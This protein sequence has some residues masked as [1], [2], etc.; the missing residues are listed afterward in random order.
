[1]A[2]YISFDWSADT[3][4]LHLMREVA[5][6]V[7]FWRRER[8]GKIN[9]N[10][11]RSLYIVICVTVGDDA[12]IVPFINIVGFSSFES[13]N[14]AA[15]L[16]LMR[17]VAEVENFRRR[18]RMEKHLLNYF[19]QYYACNSGGLPLIVPYTVYS[20]FTDLPKNFRLFSLPWLTPSPCLSRH[21]VIMA[22]KRQNRPFIR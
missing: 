3:A 22:E 19:A 4:S 6:V 9:G 1:M 13:E 14:I 7:D 17:E 2:E 10:A 11:F 5:K 15:S 8:T 12:Y 21:G 20:S 16:S 18:V